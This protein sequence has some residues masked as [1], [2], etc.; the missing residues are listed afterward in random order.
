MGSAS[1]AASSKQKKVKNRT[2]P[3]AGKE[4]NNKEILVVP[5]EGLIFLHERHGDIDDTGTDT[6]TSYIFLPQQFSPGVSTNDDHTNANIVNRNDDSKELQVKP[7]PNLILII[8][9]NLNL[10]PNFH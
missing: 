3:A 5:G 8:N 9:A 1:S 4:T 7:Y 10:N 2:P 6:G